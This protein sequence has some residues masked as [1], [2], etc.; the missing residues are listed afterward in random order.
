[1]KKYGLVGCG[2][3]GSLSPVLFGAAYPGV[4]YDLIDTDSFDRAVEVFSDGYDAVNVTAPFKGDAFRFARVTD[5]VSRRI[6]AVNILVRTD[7]G[8][9]GYNSDYLAVRKM[10][11]RYLPSGGGTVLV[12]GCG[13][14]GRA[15]AVAASDC[16]YNTVVANR[17][18]EK[19][20]GF[21][22]MAGGMSAIPLRNIPDML[23]ISTA[24]IYTLPVCIPEA[25]D[26]ISRSAILKMEASYSSPSLGGDN[27][28]GG[29][30]WLVWQAVTGYGIMTGENPDAGAIWSVAGID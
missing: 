23:G 11:E 21:C 17:S 25:A 20:A 16:G 22:S 7:G 6:G 30:Q 29:R 9:A 10:L 13:G 15:A 27:Y 24:V 3:G 18:L 19:A 2:T 12:V 28:V 4:R 5:A 26:I 14:A 1:M 8:F